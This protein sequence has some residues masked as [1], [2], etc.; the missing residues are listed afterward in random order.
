MCIRAGVRG[1]CACVALVNRLNT[2]QVVN[3]KGKTFFM[4]YLNLPTKFRGTWQICTKFGERCHRTDS[5]Q[6]GKKINFTITL[7]QLFSNPVTIYLFNKLHLFFNS[8]ILNRE[9]LVFVQKLFQ[10]AISCIKFWPTGPGVFK[11]SNK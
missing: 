7:F 3:S 10:K 5:R 11:T 2:D 1:A 8:Q 6:S 4:L 9:D